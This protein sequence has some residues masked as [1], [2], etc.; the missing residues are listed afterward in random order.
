MLLAAAAAA[1]AAVNTRH[2]ITDTRLTRGMICE[3]KT[4][5]LPRVRSKA[6]AAEVIHDLEQLDHCYLLRSILV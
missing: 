3:Y 1:A 2:F 4:Q 6:E 5:I